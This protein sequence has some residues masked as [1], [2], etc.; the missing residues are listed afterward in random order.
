MV[1]S[2][3]PLLMLISLAGCSGSEHPMSLAL[4]G[5]SPACPEPAP[6]LGTPES[7]LEDSYFV[8]FKEDV[9]VSEEA[10]RLAAAYGF[11]PRY[12]YT[13]IPCMAV[14]GIPQETV[15]ALRCEPTVDHITY[16]GTTVPT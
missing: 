1:R 11:T 12:V 3:V 7:G 13:I 10:A 16:E 4:E 15:D 9:D 8:C 6:L 5:A 2:I 14:R